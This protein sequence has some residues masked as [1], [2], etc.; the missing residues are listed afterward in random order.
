MSVSA[1]TQEMDAE[2]VHLSWAK[3]KDTS[4]ALFTSSEYSECEQNSVF[5][6]FLNV[7]V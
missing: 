3:W 5:T 1:F 4:K 6:Q 2:S 7:S